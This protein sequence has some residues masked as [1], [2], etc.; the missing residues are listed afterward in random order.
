MGLELR[1]ASLV[2]QWWFCD[3]FDSNFVRNKTFPIWLIAIIITHYYSLNLFIK[4][5][6][7]TII[8][9][10]LAPSSSFFHNLRLYDWFN[11]NTFLVY[12]IKRIVL[13]I[14]STFNN[15]RI[16]KRWNIADCLLYFFS[17]FWRTF[18]ISSNFDFVICESNISIL[19]LTSFLNLH[20]FYHYFP[21][22]LLFLRLKCYLILFLYQTF[23]LKPAKFLSTHNIVLDQECFELLV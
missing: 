15:L 23:L 8:K 10:L 3:L 21:L 6:L 18:T 16:A 14:C 22:F 9:G 20:T 11:S 1:I 13:N 2:W 12:V 7:Q 4:T 19:F 17:F 5:E